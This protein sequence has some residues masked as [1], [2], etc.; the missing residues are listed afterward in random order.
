MFASEDKYIE[1][2]NTHTNNITHL[3]HSIG[4]NI[5]VSNGRHRGHPIRVRS[6]MLFDPC[7]HRDNNNYT[8]TRKRTKTRNNQYKGKH[9]RRVVCVCCML[10]IRM[11]LNASVFIWS[12]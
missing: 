9:K 7:V 3:E 5:V 2:K 11:D 1:T 8:R 12:R 6:A 4:G 10:A